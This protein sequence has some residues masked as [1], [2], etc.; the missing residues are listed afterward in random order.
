MYTEIILRPT[1]GGVE[2]VSGK[3]RLDALLALRDEVVVF[4]P[5][6]GDIVIARLP[7]GRLQASAHPQ[8]VAL[9]R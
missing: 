9:F 2:L 7:D 3:R 1:P 8:H 5:G 4:S 6:L